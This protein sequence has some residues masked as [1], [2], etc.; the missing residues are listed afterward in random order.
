MNLNGFIF[1]LVPLQRSFKLSSGF[2]TLS[3]ATPK[4]L[5]QHELR[6]LLMCLLY[7]LGED[8]F[9]PDSVWNHGD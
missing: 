5:S 1:Y 6:L 8:Q 9:F 2:S 3:I 7:C 4:G